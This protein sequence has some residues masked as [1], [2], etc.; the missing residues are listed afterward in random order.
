ENIRRNFGPDSP[1]QARLEEPGHWADWR[2][3]QVAALLG[4]PAQ[5][6]TWTQ[7]LARL[8]P[9]PTGGGREEGERR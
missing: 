2:R 9:S 6:G 4:L 1:C 8:A 5:R 7:A 3:R